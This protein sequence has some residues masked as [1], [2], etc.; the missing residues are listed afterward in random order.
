MIFVLKAN[1]S[2]NVRTIGQV[3]DYQKHA[4]CVAAFGVAFERFIN[5]KTGSISEVFRMATQWFDGASVIK[6]MSIDVFRLVATLKIL[7]DAKNSHML[8]ACF[9]AHRDD[10]CDFVWNHLIGKFKLDN[11]DEIV[12]GGGEHMEV[13]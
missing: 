13:M 8:L 10:V 3:A 7:G 12:D 2:R 1:F 5:L 9:K 4:I 6:E 11:I